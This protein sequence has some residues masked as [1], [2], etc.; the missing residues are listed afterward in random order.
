MAP[1]T[2]LIT[3]KREEEAT[4]GQENSAKSGQERLQSGLD[5]IEQQLKAESQAYLTSALTDLSALQGEIAELKARI[6]ALESKVERTSVRSPVDG[7]ANRLSYV[8]KDAYVNTGDVLLEIVPTGSNIIVEARID[9]KDIAEIVEGQDVQISLTAYD[10]SKY[11]RMVG[12]ISKS[13][14]ADATTDQKTGEQYYNVDVFLSGELYE[15]DGSR[16]VV[17]P[18]MVASIDILSG[19][20]S[21]LDYFCNQ[22]QRQRT[23]PSEISN[24]FNLACLLPVYDIGDLRCFYPQKLII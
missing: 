10:P 15:A 2:R 24:L 16:V 7:V 8:T 11:G 19:K 9:P 21:V 14:S 13:V 17:I 23:T 3:L 1:A 6:P 4:I 18:G 5:E 22:F 12:T 20:R